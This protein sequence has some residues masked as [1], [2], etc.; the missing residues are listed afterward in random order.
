[1]P[2]FNYFSDKK[3]TIQRESIGYKHLGD[4]LYLSIFR[5]AKFLK[6]PGFIRL[7]LRKIF[8]EIICEKDLFQISPSLIKEKI[9]QYKPFHFLGYSFHQCLNLKKFL[10]ESS[11]HTLL[12]DL[13]KPKQKIEEAFDN[14]CRKEIKK[15]QNLGLHVTRASNKNHLIQYCDLLNQSGYKISQNDICK[16]WLCLH[17]NNPKESCYEIFICF[18]ENKQPLEGIGIMINPKEKIFIETGIGRNNNP[19]YKKFPAG[20]LIKWEIINF[21]IKNDYLYYDLG[22]VN[23]YATPDSKEY[24]IYRHKKKWGGDLVKYFI[25]ENYFPN[26]SLLNELLYKLLINNNQKR[27]RKY[28]F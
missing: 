6:Y 9:N 19:D 4:N 26:N 13:S 8:P 21:G 5:H 3:Y 10:K 20:D 22:G 18:D 25:Y 17:D 16:L 12:I 23:P 15:A 7:I 27:Y 11:W 14:S 2:Y 1:M 28:L 24:R